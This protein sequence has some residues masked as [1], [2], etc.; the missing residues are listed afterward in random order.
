MAKYTYD[1]G[2]EMLTARYDKSL[3][4]RCTLV[5]VYDTVMKKIY[6][7]KHFKLMFFL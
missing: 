7:L 4:L 1:F 3:E 6:F 2:V 5:V